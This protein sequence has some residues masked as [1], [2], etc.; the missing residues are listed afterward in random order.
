M[1]DLSV[2]I[3]RSEAR[4][5]ELVCYYFVL[6]LVNHCGAASYPKEINN[7]EGNAPLFI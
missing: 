4:T 6:D 5:N 7:V 1:S 3:S 2:L